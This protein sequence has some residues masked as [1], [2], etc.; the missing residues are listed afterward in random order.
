MCRQ[1][2][3]MSP[4]SVGRET[5]LFRPPNILVEICSQTF[6]T[7]YPWNYLPIET[8][9]RLVYQNLF[10]KRDLIV[11]LTINLFFIFHSPNGLLRPSCNSSFLSYVPVDAVYANSL[12]PNIFNTPNTPAIQRRIVKNL[13][14]KELNFPIDSALYKRSVSRQSTTSIIYI[15]CR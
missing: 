7:R 11:L 8:I 12:T 2:V 1:F 6:S 5:N 14:G 9:L 4:Q 13:L 3:L 15:I 10:C